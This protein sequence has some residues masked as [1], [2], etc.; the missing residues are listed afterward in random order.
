MKLRLI[1]GREVFP[2][3][4]GAMV[5]D[6]YEPKPS[7]DDAVSFIKY[8]ASRGVN[9][10]DTADVYGLGRNEKILGD[11]LTAEQKNKVVIA[12]K[13]GCTRPN[14]YEWDTDGSPEHIMKAVEES[15]ERLK[16]K[17][18]YLYQLHAP[19]YKV[20][21]KESIKSMKELQANGIVK[22]IGLSNVTFEELREAQEIVEVVS[23]ENHYNFAFRKDEEE[24]LPYLTENSIAY[25]PYFPLGSGRLLKNPKLI[26][27]A[28]SLGSS[29]S[30][31]AL[32]WILHKWPT[33]I[34]I[35]GTRSNVHLD[36]NLK[37]AEIE[38]PEK[39]MKELD[40][41]Y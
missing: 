19:D 7:Y 31:I 20:P 10:I 14:G 2:I 23:V 13:A 32:S 26:K 17:Q 24:L 28:Q 9:F 39:I 37:A 29:P 41:I 16:I 12:T 34:P 1:A 21:F 11:A 40:S 18:I 22:H 30:Q 8:A 38:I 5:L 35:P 3:G 15:L 6:E 25:L 36:D 33:A 27:F 4:L